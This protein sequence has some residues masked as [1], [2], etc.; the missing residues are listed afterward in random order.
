VPVTVTSPGTL[1]LRINDGAILED[2]AGNDLDTTPALLDDTTITVRNAY[3]TWALTN[4]ISSAPGADKDGDGVNN[5][6]EFVLGGTVG[7]NDL[8]KLPEVTM[9]ATDMIITFER[10]R[11]SI[12]GITGL[13]VEV[14]TTLTGWPNSYT[15]GT[16]TLNS[17][18]GVTVLE[19]SPT[20]FD[21]IT[22]TVPKGTDPKKFARLSVDV[23]E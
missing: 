12:D 22:V 21:T 11:S 16:T 20:G 1:V 3:Q 2:L 6:I 13:E 15:V 5:A 14:G 17:D 4:A 9:T 7:G 18:S 8:D 19:N 10:Q 23:T